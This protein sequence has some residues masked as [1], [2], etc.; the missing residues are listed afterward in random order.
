[1][2]NQKKSLLWQLDHPATAMPSFLFGTMHVRD[3]QAFLFLNKVYSCL[4]QCEAVAVEYDLST[5]TA[6]DIS[7]ALI[8]PGEQKIS[9]YFS[10]KSFSKLQAILFKAFQLDIRTYERFVPLFFI[11]LV[12]EQLLQQ[13]QPLALDAQIW[14]YAGENGK[15]RLGIETLEEQMA[16]LEKIPLDHQLQL[17]RGMARN[18]SKFRSATLRSTAIYQH[19]DPYRL[20]RLVRRSSQGL[21]KLLLFRR[22]HV[23]AGR[24]DLI[25]RQQPTLCAIGAGHLAGKEGVLRLLKRKGYKISPLPIP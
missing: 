2:G 4:R 23:M 9:D 21:R 22:N 8:L 5:F 17:L 6:P 12:S 7:Q 25:V 3:R 10:R 15:I 11:N 16:V 19:A 24:I 14:Q 13:D 20:Y 1:M 18:I